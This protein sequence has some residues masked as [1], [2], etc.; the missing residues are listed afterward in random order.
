MAVKKKAYK[1]DCVLFLFNFERKDKH[2]I[3]ER[4]CHVGGSPMK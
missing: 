2:L 3:K 1:R 4:R